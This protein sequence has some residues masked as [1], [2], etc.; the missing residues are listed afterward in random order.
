[1]HLIPAIVTMFSDF[2]SKRELMHL[3]SDGK[4]EVGLTATEPFKFSEYA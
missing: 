3:C 4:F 2:K 1:M